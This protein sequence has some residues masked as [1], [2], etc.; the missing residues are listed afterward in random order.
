MSTQAA[1]S[2]TNLSV[3]R[4]DRH[5][6]ARADQPALVWEGNDPGEEARWTYA[7]LR[8]EVARFGNVLRG[9][10]VRQGDRV[11]IYL[12]MVPQAAVACLVCAR[13]GAGVS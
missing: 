1:G 12:Q 2:T 8:A 13:I 3:N 9:L 10:G 4:L 6:A 7:E 5:L 11:G